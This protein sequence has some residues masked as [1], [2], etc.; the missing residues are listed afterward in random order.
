LLKIAVS[1][2]IHAAALAL[3]LAASSLALASCSDKNDPLFANKSPEQV[4]LLK[5][6]KAVYTSVCIACHNAD[7]KR[8]GALGPAI[9]GTNADVVR[10]KVLENKYPAGYTPKRATQ[11]MAPLAHLKD[12]IPGLVAFLEAM[13]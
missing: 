5:R 6:G 12:D 10:A 9:A 11:Q 3:C 2:P 13:R 1:S 8:E 7:P 4:A